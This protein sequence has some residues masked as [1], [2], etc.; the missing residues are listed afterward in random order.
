MAEK[1]RTN[2]KLQV[3][4]H[5]DYAVAFE[6]VEKLRGQF[7]EPIIVMNDYVNNKTQYKV[8][9]GEFKT[10]AEAESFRKILDKDFK[11][12]SIVY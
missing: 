9:L 5:M 3:G 10:I 4:N 6:Q 1:F 11:I 7:I 2:Y 12:D 8:L